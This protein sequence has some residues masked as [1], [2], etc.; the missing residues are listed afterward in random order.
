MEQVKKLLANGLVKRYKRTMV[1]LIVLAAK[2][3]Q[4]YVTDINNFIWRMCVSYRKLNV[5]TK[6]LKYP[7][8]RCKYAVDV[9]NVGAHNIWII[10]LNACKG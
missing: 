4:E 1:Y 5:F 8:P 6:P 10:I 7:I 9:I 2:T 3:Y